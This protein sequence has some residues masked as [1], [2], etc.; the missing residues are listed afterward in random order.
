MVSVH[1]GAAKCCNHP[2]GG[3]EMQVSE[4]NGAENLRS[5][6]ARV[7]NE[8]TEDVEGIRE[9]VQDL[10][11]W[12][13]FV[14]RHPWAV[15]AGAA[16]VGYLLVPKRARVIYADA[17]TLAEVAQRLPLNVQASDRHSPSLIGGLFRAAGSSVMHGLIAI[18]GRQLGT[19]A[20]QMASKVVDD[21]SEQDEAADRNARAFE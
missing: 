13:G 7:R 20:S 8:L 11:D 1:C 15:A 3:E 14:R 18:A 4:T 6:M 9:K 10:K 12:R 5:Q 19:I 17:E 16:A 2:P 21:E